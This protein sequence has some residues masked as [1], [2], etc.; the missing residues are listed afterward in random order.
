MMAEAQDDM[1]KRFTFFVPGRV[2]GKQR[3]RTVRS[4][5]GG[6]HS[7]TPR[8]TKLY[9]AAILEAY[10]A[11][12]GL[13]LGA[14]DGPIRLD[15][16]AV[17]EMP[18]SWPAWKV[19][20]VRAAGL[21]VTNTPDCDNILKCVDALNGIAWKDDRQIYSAGIRKLYGERPGLNVLIGF[22][23]AIERS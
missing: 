15:L 20:A 6:V 14:H 18:K 3:A 19:R 10:Y 22:E 17:F 2:C 7:Y 9:E 8:K 4:K 23:P 1:V 12:G 21:P 16:V 5:L 11:A 13:H